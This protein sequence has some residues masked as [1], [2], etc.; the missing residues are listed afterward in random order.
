MLDHAE[1]QI[2]GP[3]DGSPPPPTFDMTALS[4]FLSVLGNTGGRDF[5]NR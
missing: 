5:K 3:K 1:V 4:G 2:S